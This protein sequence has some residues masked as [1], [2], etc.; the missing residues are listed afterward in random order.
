M[1]LQYSEETILSVAKTTL[2]SARS[3]IESLSVFGFVPASLAQF[4]V[5][6]QA[7]EALPSETQNRISLRD[8]TQSKD[9]ALDTCDHWGRELRIRLQLAFGNSSAEARSFPS[10]EFRSAQDSENAMMNVMKILLQLANKYNETLVNNGQT[11]EVLARGNELLDDLRAADSAQE[12]QKVGKTA[13]TQDRHQHFL[14]LYDTVNRINKI[15]RLVFKDDP[16]KRALF[17]S[18][19]PTRKSVAVQEAGFGG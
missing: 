12:T 16:A 10:K 3:E 15:G 5:D 7:A 13:A 4:E 11:A 6:I 1:P 2:S 9:E 19:W 18:K 17:K 8:F 14:G